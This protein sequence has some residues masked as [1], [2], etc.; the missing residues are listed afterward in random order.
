MARQ[1]I[2]QAAEF[3]INRLRDKSVPESQGDIKPARRLI[4][5]GV[6]AR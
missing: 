4:R 6:S 2:T 3:M 5:R 1:H